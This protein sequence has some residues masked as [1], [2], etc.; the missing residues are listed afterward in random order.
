VDI[1][2]TSVNDIMDE[3]YFQFKEPFSERNCTMNV[4]KTLENKDSFVH[5]DN[6]KLTQILRNLLSNALKF[7]DSGSV[8]IGYELRDNVLE[9]FVK[10]T[11]I[12]I[13][14][15]M[16]E[17]I[18]DHFR[19]ANN[20][21]FFN[22]S[23]TGLGLSISKGFVELLGGQIWVESETGKGAAFYFTIPFQPAH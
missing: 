2:P 9:F 11:G 5:T 4:R 3:L 22:L 1:Q 15:N 19:K 6:N 14:P 16:H 8:D 20:H 12:G 18:F 23:G 13:D 10:D 17:L 7:T 21:K